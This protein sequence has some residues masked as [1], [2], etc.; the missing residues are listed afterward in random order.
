M[1]EGKWVNI[2]R[3]YCPVKKWPKQK[4]QQQI[5]W[6]NFVKFMIT[7]V[8]DSHAVVKLGIEL[9]KLSVSVKIFQILSTELCVSSNGNTELRLLTKPLEQERPL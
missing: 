7:E 5:K 4:E 1:V 6:P 2:T 3:F 9:I 8:Y